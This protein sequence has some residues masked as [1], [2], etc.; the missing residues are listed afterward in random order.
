MAQITLRVD[1]EL[2]HDIRDAAQRTGRSVNAWLA[3]VARAA[4][5]PEMEG[6]EVTRLRERLRRAGLLSENV[7]YDGPPVDQ[8][9]FERAR[10]AAGTGTPLSEMVSWARGPR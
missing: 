5:D 1:D 9:E 6:D 7:P 10:K 3:F 8:E 2:A 4:T